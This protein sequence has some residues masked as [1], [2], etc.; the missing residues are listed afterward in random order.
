M[1][2]YDALEAERQKCEARE[3]ILVAQLDKA[4]K[5]I[6]ELKDQNE[7]RENT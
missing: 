7:T 6:A 1:I 3:A 2:C 5:K 4:M